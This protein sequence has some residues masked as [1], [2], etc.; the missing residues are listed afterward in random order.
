MSSPLTATF[1]MLLVTL[2]LQSILYGM[3]LL[4]AW[5]YFFWYPKDGWFIK[6]SVV[7]ITLFETAE[8]V[9]FFCATYA[10]LIDGFGDRENLALWNVPIRL[11]LLMTYLTIFVAH[12]Y[13]AHCIYRLHQRDKVIPLLILVLAIVCLGGGLGQFA[14]NFKIKGF[15]ELGE[16]KPTRDIQAVFALAADVLITGALCW[17]LNRSKAGGI[18]ST[19]KLLNYLIITAINRGV[20]TMF[21]AALNLILFSTEP[22]TFYFMLWVILGG[23]FYMNSMIATLNT[24]GFAI[25]KTANSAGPSTLGEISMIKIGHPS[26]T[27]DSAIETTN[28]HQDPTVE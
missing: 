13:F 27:G 26:Q 10:Y 18:Q 20:L 1:G 22:G 2:F 8:T 23:K 25:G 9:L 3:G 24:R 6:I 21:S 7:L 11:V 5:L 4:Q 15:K 12:V 16:T 28:Q 14:E 19:N 17:R